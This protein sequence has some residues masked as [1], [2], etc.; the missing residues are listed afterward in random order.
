MNAQD[1]KMKNLNEQFIKLNN[2]DARKHFAFSEIEQIFNNLIQKRKYLKD[3]AVERKRKLKSSKEF[4]E[5][6]NQC[7]DLNGWISERRRHAQT[8]Y[9]AVEHVNSAENFYLIGKYLNKHE[10]LDKE[11]SANRT[12]LDRLKQ[13]AT[14]IEASNNKDNVTKLVNSIENNWFNLENEAL[15][16]G[17]YLKDKKDKADLSAT[18]SDV[19][20][21]MKNLE[22]SLNTKYNTGDL[23]SVK[24]ALKKHDDLRKQ[25]EVEV[26]LVRDLSKVDSNQLNRSNSNQNQL[27]T[28]NAVREYLN[29]F[30]LLNPLIEQK[31][32]QLEVDLEEQQLIFDMNEELKLIEQSKKQIEIITSQLPMSLLEAQNACKKQAELER[33]IGNKQPIIERMCEQVE[34]LL[35]KEVCFNLNNKKIINKSLV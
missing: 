30:N 33:S 25:L 8:I 21:R 35:K 5:F 22:D 7:D 16:K 28:E 2:P 4:F 26:D 1:E 29:K 15:S 18:L 19:D 34:N 3:T 12:R 9:N 17:K 24:E 6:K 20:T 14:L 11:L 27:A 23:R 31:Q 10:A 13:I 32:N